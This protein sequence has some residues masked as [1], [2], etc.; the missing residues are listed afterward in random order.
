M[1]G[2]C[3]VQEWTRL[4][5]D[6][7]R[8]VGLTPKR[9]RIQVWKG[10][11]HPSHWIVCCEW[12]RVAR[13]IR[14]GLKMHGLGGANADQN[15]QDLYAAGSLRHCGIEAVAALFNCWEVETCGIRNC[16]EEVWICGIGIGPGNCRMLPHRQSGDRL[17]EGE[18]VRV[19]VTGLFVLLH[20]SESTNWYPE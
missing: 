16:L 1:E 17:W 13:L 4:R 9:W 5:H 2:G 14:P 3:Q 6:Q 20:G 8:L 19:E 7:I 11:R 18:R 15:S 10:Y 12:W